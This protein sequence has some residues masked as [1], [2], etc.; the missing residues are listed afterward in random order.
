MD[1]ELS[2]VGSVDKYFAAAE[3]ESILYELGNELWGK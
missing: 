1:S 2:K 3:W